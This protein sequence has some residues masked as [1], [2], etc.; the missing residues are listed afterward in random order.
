MARKRKPIEISAD[1]QADAVKTAHRA[2]QSIAENLPAREPAQT[3]TLDDTIA[4]IGELTEQVKAAQLESLKKTVEQ[5][6]ETLQRL[7]DK[8]LQ[9]L[10]RLPLSEIEKLPQEKKDAVWAELTRQW[11]EDGSLQ[12]LAAVA[13][14]MQETFDAMQ[15]KMQAAAAAM[16]EPIKNIGAALEGV[17]EHFL[18][19][20]DADT[21]QAFET[22]GKLSPYIKAEAD[23]HPE[24]YG[25]DAGKSRAEKVASA[26]ELIAA[27]ARRA[28]ADGLEIPHLR[29]EDNAAQQLEMQLD[30]P[31]KK[32]QAEQTRRQHIQEAHERHKQ[33]AA[34]GALQDING[35]I[36]TI[37]EKG[38]GFQYFTSEVIKNLP[39]G[40]EMKDLM[41]DDEGKINL[42]DLT[43][44]GR[45][46]EEVDSIHT[47]FLMW[48]LSL[49]YC[50]NDLRETNSTNAIIPVNLPAV[51]REMTIDAR[52]RLREYNSA[53]GKKELTTRTAEGLDIADLRR[54][55]FMEFLRPF[56]N[57]AAF[58]GQ[59][60]Y[61]IVGFHSYNK[62]TETMY[63]SIPYLFKLVE[64]SKLHATR[65]GAI[66]NVFH[67]NIMTENQTAVEVA[68]RIA[69]GVI[70]R[71]LRPDAKTYKNAAAAVDSSNPPPRITT[72]A[73]KFSSIIKDCPQFQRELDAI[74]TRTGEAETAAIRA[75][76]PAKEIA[77]ARKAD[78]KTDPQ[79]IN[80]KLKDI[81]DAA[82]RIITEKSDMPQYYSDLKIR[83]G[84]LPAYKA[85]TNSTQGDKLIITH[86]GKNP[87][88]SA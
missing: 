80:S 56:L 43:Q 3:V 39:G 68:N 10:M 14:Q 57:M 15:Q 25:K 51:L 78:H 34:E 42:Y 22:M 59:D 61:Q 36:S 50:N 84:K 19:A 58:F 40:I 64:Y 24:L 26:D 53:T 83:T 12:R 16:L 13:E 1:P 29:A 75:G 11:T 82:I 9:R 63:I 28:R 44:E 60:L 54:D 18:K 77:A 21:M 2:A 76:K 88:Y 32:E 31:D 47:G 72:W 17:R 41:L 55:K 33:A 46:L 87:H 73:D 45:E 6:G 7:Q 8:E 4:D 49:A 38:L 67:A 37:V 71:G 66:V 30:F 5:T 74:R 62:A 81:F 65:H 70:L 86:R 79:R 35:H 69:M 20:I 23:E 27:A 48:L 85:P 52:P